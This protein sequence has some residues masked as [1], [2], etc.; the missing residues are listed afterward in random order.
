MDLQLTGKRAVVT[1][2]SQGIGFAVGRVLAAEGADVALVARGADR[3]AE[4]AGRI[5]AESGRRVIAVPADTGDDA[6]VA[7]MAQEVLR[8][9]G[10]AD[11]LVNS[12]ATASSGSFPEDALEAEIN[13]KVRGYLRTARA[14]APAM[15][16]QG[17][18]RV[19]N[20]SGSA[21]RQ[22]GS[23]VGSVRNV[24]V[25]AL[26][27]NLADEL[28]PQGVNVV[29]VH[30]GMTRTERTPRTLATMAGARGVTVP[31]LEEA[32]A[33]G[34]SIGR[35]V[36]AEEVADVVAFLASPRSVALNGDP[37]IA[38]GGARGPIHY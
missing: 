35:I 3:L 9:F 1:G 25:A 5:A 27:K 4:A 31:E 37:V 36:T 2:G 17:W 24:A 14:F 7:A 22:T 30:P 38:S 23:L 6:S 26:T 20:I 13:V 32:I 34:V 11:I 21:A 29:V 18:G 15:T 12:A 19:V 10:G 16:A 8:E 28:G 33:A